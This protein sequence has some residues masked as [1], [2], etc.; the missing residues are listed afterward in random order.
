MPGKHSAIYPYP[1]EP[2]YYLNEEMYRER[3]EDFPETKP[4][5]IAWGCD[6]LGSP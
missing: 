3:I 1:F 2:S 6:A 5:L 4:F